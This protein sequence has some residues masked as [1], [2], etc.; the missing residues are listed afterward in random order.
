MLE[1]WL[2]DTESL[3]VVNVVSVVGS[4]PAPFPEARAFRHGLS[5]EFANTFSASLSVS[6]P[7]SID[8]LLPTSLSFRILPLLCAI[9]LYHQAAFRIVFSSSSFSLLK[10]S[11]PAEYPSRV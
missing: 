10:K 9:L 1:P 5:L 11:S 8:V 7:S 6:G 2:S 4:S 3:H